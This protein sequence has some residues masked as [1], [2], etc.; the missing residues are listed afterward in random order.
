MRVSAAWY[1]WR[2]IYS[3]MISKS[4]PLRNRSRVYD[5][6]IR[7]VLLYGSEGWPV[8]ERIASVLTNCDRRM[9]RYI[10]GVAWE[11]NLR[12][13]EMTERY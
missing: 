2:D 1:K 13:E 10:A 9:L 7:S 12:S 6:C 5:A 4:V 3:L 8:T 11:D